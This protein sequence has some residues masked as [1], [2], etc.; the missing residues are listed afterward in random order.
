MTGLDLVPRATRAI[1]EVLC[2]LRPRQARSFAVRQSDPA[3]SADRYGLL[4]DS[5]LEQ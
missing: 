1:E 3:G 5:T 2:T 4:T